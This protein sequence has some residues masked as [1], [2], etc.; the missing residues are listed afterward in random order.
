MLQGELNQAK[1]Q[2]LLG[3]CGWKVTHQPL[4]QGRVFLMFVAKAQDLAY[5]RYSIIQYSILNSEFLIISCLGP[6]CG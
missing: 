1:G 6:Q 4:T 3:P 2:I 5:S